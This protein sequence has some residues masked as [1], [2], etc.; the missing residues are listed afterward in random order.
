[1]DK[2]TISA[3]TGNSALANFIHAITLII[4]A[5]ML[6]S[7]IYALKPLYLSLVYENRWE[8][9]VYLIAVCILIPVYWPSLVYRMLIILML[10]FPSFIRKFEYN[11]IEKNKL[12]PI[13]IVIAVRNEPASV[14]I[15][16][17][18]SLVKLEYPDYEIVVAD[19]CYSNI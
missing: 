8:G 1:M 9:I 3:I 14:V 19:K 15:P 4:V 6:A 16:L 17:L 18:R 5:G 2:H 10:P 7:I 13:S 11:L 12:P